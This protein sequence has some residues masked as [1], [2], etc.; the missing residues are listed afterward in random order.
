MLAKMSKILWPIVALYPLAYLNL[1]M[2]EEM[3]SAAF[4]V[5]NFILGLFCVLR[6]F[7]LG[8]KR[9]ITTD[10]VTYMFIYIFFVVA[11]LYQYKEKVTF[12]SAQ[13][14][15]EEQFFFTTVL[16]L[17][18]VLIYAIFYRFFLGKWCRHTHT[19]E[20]YCNEREE[21][22]R[23]RIWLLALA[24]IATV[25][26][27]F[28]YR[29]SPELLFFRK[30]KGA[31]IS[32][33]F[34]NT[35]ANL[36]FSQVIR[37][38]PVI[39]TSLYLFI[40]KR[41]D[42]YFLALACM[43]VVSNF[44]LSLPRF[45][46]A[47]VYIPLVFAV[48]KSLI[49]RPITFRMILLAGILYVFPFLNQGRTVKK[50]EEIEFSFEPNYDMF[51][52]GHFDAFQNGARV[53][54]NDL[55]TWGNQLIGCIFFWV[56]RSMWPN[57]PIGS[58]GF[59]AEE[60]HLR[61]DH[62]SVNYWAEGWINYG[63]AGMLVFSVIL[64]FINAKCDFIFWHRRHSLLFTYDFLLYLGMIIFILRGDMISSVAFIV[65]FLV[66]AYLCYKVCIKTVEPKTNKEGE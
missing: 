22:P 17:L 38:I 26:T 64:A 30:I 3:N 25:I 33:E 61:F 34:S 48:W 66:S 52:H 44:P 21:I 59:I 39:L 8:R 43:T 42:L 56:P 65:G 60:F 5:V 58:G 63:M 45:Y 47:G 35:S 9:R 28:A 2:P 53:M 27:L 1:T 41:Y 18:A 16:L 14:L 46:V 15:S 4:Q 57:K 50:A 31:A 24:G 51:L 36:L 13:H 6:I 37:P 40:Y 55:V 12:W 7:P 11:P 10:A 54:M 19:Y 20:L 62:I 29:H 49:D 23:N 32:S